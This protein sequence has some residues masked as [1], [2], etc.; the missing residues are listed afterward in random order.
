MNDSHQSS[1]R[2]FSNTIFCVG[3]VR[4]KSKRQN[5]LRRGVIVDESNGA[6]KSLAAQRIGNFWEIGEYKRVIKR[7]DDGGT[8]VD[9]FRQMVQERAGIEKKYAGML[10]EW[11]KRWE[12]KLDRHPSSAQDTSLQTA[13]RSVLSESTSTSETHSETDTKLRELADQHVLTWRKANFSRNKMNKHKATKK[14]EDKFDGAQKPWAKLRVKFD[15]SLKVYTTNTKVCSALEKK[16]QDTSLTAED[17][18][19][20]EE[21]L[22]K[23][24]AW[25]AQ[26]H[27]KCEQRLRKLEEDVPRY[28]AEM[29]DAFVFCQDVEQ[30]R[31]DFMQHALELYMLALEPSIT[32]SA[33]EAADTA[34]TLVNSDADMIRYSESCGDG[35]SLIVPTLDD[36][37]VGLARADDQYEARLST[38]SSSTEGVVYRNKPSQN[39]LDPMSPL[40]PSGGFMASHRPSIA[41]K[42][43]DN[44]SN[45]DDDDWGDD[46]VPAPPPP[47]AQIMMVAMYDYQGEDDQ[48]LSLTVGDVVTQLEQPDEQGWCKGMPQRLKYRTA[49]RLPVNKTHAIRHVSSVLP[50]IF[51]GHRHGQ[52]GQ[53]WILPRPLRVRA[54]HHQH[55]LRNII[56]SS[57]SS[58]RGPIL[59]VPIPC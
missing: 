10:K 21:R 29:Q 11:S 8:H 36:G 5:A 25:A 50:C 38:Y 7:I 19:K 49:S 13:W 46:A 23:F 20:T 26:N 14:A 4:S 35:M 58:L 28:R 42:P 31:I 47:A 22:Q 33:K 2:R 32:P 1:G 24:Q 40:S 53:D 17:R 48:E 30:K 27:F 56:P 34:I 44:D 43:D 39:V 45:S 18:V 37:Q 41:L 52:N 9:D 54:R 3:G 51:V 6:V 59:R 12:G 57:L 16:L 15:K 55:R